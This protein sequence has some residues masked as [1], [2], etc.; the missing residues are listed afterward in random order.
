MDEFKEFFTF[1]TSTKDGKTIELAV[2]EE[3]EFDGKNYVAAAL[4]E[5]D[6]INHEYVF[7]YKCVIHDDDVS[8]EKIH[9]ATE[10]RRV[11]EAY[12]EMEE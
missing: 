11:C 10:Y 1:E 7:I 12:M 8:F 3:F 6:A 4:V 9:N 5:N 2:T